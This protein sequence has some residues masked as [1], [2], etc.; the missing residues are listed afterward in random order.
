M[1][2]RHSIEIVG[3]R[4]ERL[5][6][7]SIHHRDAKGNAYLLC[8]C[9]CGTEIVVRRG[10]LLSTRR[11]TRSCGCLK[12]DWIAGHTKDEVGNR[13]GYLLVLSRAGS[14]GPVNS[15]KATW[16]CLCDPAKGG[17]GREVV[18][19][20]RCLRTGHTSS[21]GC[22]ADQLTSVRSTIH[23][24]SKGG[25]ITPEYN[26][27]SGMNQRCTNPKA[28]GYVGDTISVCPR[29]LNSF[30]DFLADVGYR[31]GSGYFLDRFPDRLGDYELGNVRWATKIQIA[32]N[33]KSNVLV[34]YEGRSQTVAQW[35]SERGLNPSRLYMRLFKLQWPIGEALGFLRHKNRRI[36][37]T[38]ADLRLRKQARMAVR[39]AIIAGKLSP[40]AHVSC[41]QCGKPSQAYHHHKGYEPEFW[42]DVVP[43]CDKCHGSK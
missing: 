32:N 37:L 10:D 12:L 15:K 43:M 14:S 41:V 4:S 34:T 16:N 6:V 42:T 38:P 18:V 22:L 1:S 30:A 25:K 8:R 29:W 19:N 31:P 17:C 40:L 28:D 11:P 26:A 33:A 24:A 2:E 35:S 20:G 21:C 23:G 36:K 9:D 27:W 39:S 5:V 13:Y 7:L 3:Y